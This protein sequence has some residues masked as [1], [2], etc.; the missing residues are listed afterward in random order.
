VLLTTDV[1]VPGSTGRAALDVVKGPG[2]PVFDVIELLDP[3]D[4]ERL[5]TYATGGAVVSDP[6]G[7]GREQAAR[8]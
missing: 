4:Q 5:R 7:T 1:P 6:P 2:R 3:S 8:P